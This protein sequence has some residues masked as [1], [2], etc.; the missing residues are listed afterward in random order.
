MPQI[1]S[2]GPYLVFIWVNEGKPPEPIHVHIAEKRPVKNSTNVWITSSGKCLLANNNSKIPTPA[3]KNIM[4][5]IET[6]SKEI[7]LTWNSLFGNVSYYC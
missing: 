5:I 7:I 1:F 2:I 4:R 3:L 6:R